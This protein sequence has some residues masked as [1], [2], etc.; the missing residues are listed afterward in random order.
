[1]SAVASLQTHVDASPLTLAIAL[2]DV[3]LILLFVAVGEL[4]HGYDLLAHPGRVV[5]TALPFLIGWGVASVPAGVYA[6]Q[7]YRS[8]RSAI[9]RTG[10][11]WV[12]AVLVGQALRA[13]ALFHGDFAVTFMLVSLGVGLVLLVPWR[14]AVGYL[15]RA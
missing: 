9:A 6:P 14:A 5:G 7:V 1:M 13:T 12:G 2:G 8:L 4:Q 15:G 11:A 10:V 3:A